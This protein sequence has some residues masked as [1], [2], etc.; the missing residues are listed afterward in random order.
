MMEKEGRESL[1]R[2]GPSQTKNH[3]AGCDSF[4]GNVTEDV[5]CPA[6]QPPSW[7]VSG[8]TFIPLDKTKT[9]FMPGTRVRP[10]DVSPALFPPES[11]VQQEKAA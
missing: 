2:G 6:K 8:K 1:V 11:W 9:G 5:I 7:A 10:C 3:P 4:K